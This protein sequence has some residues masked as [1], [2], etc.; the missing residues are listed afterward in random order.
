MC[1]GVTNIK[2]W[3]PTFENTSAKSEDYTK[4]RGGVLALLEV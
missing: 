1:V 3:G 4:A 2:N